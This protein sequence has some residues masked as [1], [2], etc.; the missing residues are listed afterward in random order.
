MKCYWCNKGGKLLE[1]INGLGKSRWL[2][3][4]CV[5][6]TQNQINYARSR[7]GELAK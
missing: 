4:M 2:C 6:A 7:Y 1:Y 5:V 3:K